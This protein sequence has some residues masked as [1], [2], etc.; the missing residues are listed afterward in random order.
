[1]KTHIFLLIILIGASS[2]LIGQNVPIS[3]CGKSFSYDNAGNRIKRYVCYESAFLTS[4]D[5]DKLK[6]SVVQ[7]NDTSEN[8][9][10]RYDTDPIVFPNPVQG[11]AYIRHLDKTKE[12]RISL[13]SNDGKELINRK[14]DHS[15]IDMSTLPEGIYFI[16]IM[17]EGYNKAFKIIKSNN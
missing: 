1:M 8:E 13:L 17:R 9:S 14:Y 2:V 10:T 12:Y 7:E 11:I 3:S 4:Q 5:L 6:N 16:V 15:G